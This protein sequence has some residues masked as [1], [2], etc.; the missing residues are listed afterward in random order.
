MYRLRWMQTIAAFSSAILLVA[1]IV[2]GIF[3]PAPSPFQYHVFRI[4]FALAVA[5]LAFTVPGNLKVSLE[6]PR[7]MMMRVSG[8][9]AGFIAAYF[10]APVFLN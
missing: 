3:I 7:L 10:F 9:L 1:L 4:V 6:G 2:I 5:S 8:A